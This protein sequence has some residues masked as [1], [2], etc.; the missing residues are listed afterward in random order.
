MF[1]SQLNDS[2]IFVGAI[3]R[4]LAAVSFAKSDDL[5]DAK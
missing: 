5:Y 3:S 4:K 1:N 2:P